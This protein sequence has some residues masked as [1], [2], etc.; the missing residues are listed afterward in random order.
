MSRKKYYL[1][2]SGIF[3]FCS[4]FFIGYLLV[5]GKT[6]INFKSDGMNQHYRSLIYYTRYLRGIIG[7]LIH[8]RKLSIPLW[9]FSIGEGADIIQTFHT[10]V[11]GDPF[12]LIALFFP[13]R[14]MYVAYSFI[15]L[16]KM[17]L[18]GI[19]FS[20]L[21]FYLNKGSFCGTL[22]GSLVYVFCF[23]AIKNFTLHFFFF[24][25]YLYL[26]LLIL[27]LEKVIKENKCVLF[28]VAVFLSAV[29]N[30]Y[31]FYMEALATALYG[32]LRT[33]AVYKA[34]LKRIFTKLL[35]L[36]G[37]AVIGVLMAAVILSPMIPAYMSDSRMSVGNETDLLYTPFFYERLFTIFVSNDSPYDI[38]LGYASPVL[39]S[40]FILLRNHKKH[41][42]LLLVNVLCAIF[43]LFPIFGKIW[44]GFSYVSQ[45]WSFVIALPIA[46][47][48]VVAWDEF[49]ENK[50]YLLC[51]LPLIF[52]AA[53]FTPWGRNERVIIPFLLCV[54]FCLIAV[55][56]SEERIIKPN[57]RQALLI[58][59]IVFNIL[60]IY[61]FHLSPRGGDLI[62]DMLSIE[63][64][65]IFTE[66]SEAYAMKK[67][68]EKEDGFFRYSMNY[69]TNNA[70]ILYDVHS[71]NFYWSITNPYDQRFRNDIGLRDRLSWQLIGYDDRAELETLANVRY[72]IVKPGY[73]GTVPYGFELADT[74]DGYPI[75][76]NRYAL[77]FGY[78][79]SKTVS[80]DDYEKL[81][82]L[83][84]QE[85]MMQ[86]I[87]LDDSAASAS[88]LSD[89]RYISYSVECGEG[90][91]AVEKGFHVD[92]EDGEVHLKLN[93]PV[94]RELY[95]LIK[96]LRFIDS[97]GIVE[98]DNIISTVRIEANDV[99]SYIYHMTD[100]NRYYY[101]KSDYV[102]YFGS[103]A[104]GI[105]DI[106]MT[107]YLEGTYVYDD[108]QVVSKS[109]E[110]YETYVRDLSDEH[111]NNVVFE[112]NRISGDI[113]VSEEKY[114]LLS[115]PY[116]KG[117]KATVDGEKA[118]LLPA[119]VH[120]MALYLKPGHHTIEL[121]YRT[122][123]LTPGIFLSV[124]GFVLFGVTAFLG[125]KKRGTE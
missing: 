84:K 68:T 117:W 8:E 45:R 110:G 97:E 88:L 7:G 101:G 66:T 120:Y 124:L 121:N 15:M 20:E 86:A 91:T 109:M 23:W 87:V 69:P 99:R 9:D 103:N 98:D 113:D 116:S 58:G 62:S 79:Y 28:T 96:G 72:Y 36:L 57:L 24:V 73:P 32:M 39:L 19:F 92:R 18:S 82:M 108:I 37:C 38:C 47:D 31:F 65:K 17:Y 61:D 112:A 30:L 75:Y 105:D 60:Y 59:I 35:Q 100:K 115:V 51:C 25:P 49:K 1:I 122:P 56:D 74:V 89:D 118:E 34:D 2:Y 67:Y 125:K 5:N 29:S 83:E 6:N 90:V 93:S 104:E 12:V 10:H 40:L 11:I 81:N 21:C 4:L 22:A 95:V 54:I 102:C 14:Y 13:E 78:T 53:F 107:L 50:K 44:N 63:E 114:L 80:V 3:L 27:G 16:V 55:L 43:V 41:P 76:E 33:V 26:P 42:F 106:T 94:D 70:S 52:C 85:M 48:L 46:Y 119:N 71:T 64:A 123:G 77:P 111:L